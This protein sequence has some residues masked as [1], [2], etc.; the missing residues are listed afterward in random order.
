MQYQSWHTGPG[1]E[2]EELGDGRTEG[3]SAIGDG[4][5][6]AISLTPE[7][8]GMH[9]CIFESLQIIGLYIGNLLYY[10]LQLYNIVI[11]NF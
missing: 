3:F 2:G 7:A 8:G 6:A 10:T 11:H 9:C 5:K 1:K 4:R